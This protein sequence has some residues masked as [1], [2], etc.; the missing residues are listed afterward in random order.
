M[1]RVL[2]ILKRQ[3]VFILAAGCASVCAYGEPRRGDVEAPASL[4]QVD[5]MWIDLYSDLSPATNSLAPKRLTVSG[6]LDRSR[7]QAMSLLTPPP[8][9]RER[10]ASEALLGRAT[11][12]LQEGRVGEALVELRDALSLTPQDPRLLAYA[13]ACYSQLQQFDRAAEYYARYMDLLPEDT[14]MGASY[15]AVL[16]RLSRFDDAEK[17]LAQLNQYQ[18][19]AI[20]VRFNRL[21][22]D[23]I[24][25]R[26]NQPRDFWEKRSLEE[27]RQ[28]IRWVAGDQDGLIAMLGS[29]DYALL[30]QVTLGTVSV[31]QII[32]A[33]LEC[34][35]ADELV[36]KGNILSARAHWVNASK[37]IDPYGMEN[38]L[39]TAS[40]D[41]G[42]VN[43]A[44]RIRK[45]QAER[46]PQWATAWLDLGRLYLR[47]N[48]RR[49][50][51]SAIQAAQKMQG[52]DEGWK[53]FVLAGALALDG[54]LG[55]AQQIF[56]ELVRRDRDQFRRWLDAD[57]AL[58][59]GFDKVPNHTAILR[60]LEIGPEYESL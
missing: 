2:S 55:E 22:L 37:I 21:C 34:A 4:A 1:S 39:A 49:P 41:L 11:A 6:E 57:P 47:A 50:G 45:R 24:R 56:T 8:G 18:P 12:W 23:L 28:L 42:D 14:A 31:E 5:G 36:K 33:E 46:F 17:V 9:D 25:E 54:S 27:A 59:S 35:Q 44:L 19:D 16:M 40:E 20:I 32:E 15:S 10:R 52:A 38:E 43:E 13:A 58:R 29:S 30:C 51:L 60:F 48:Q 26:R 53:K 3:A 7:I